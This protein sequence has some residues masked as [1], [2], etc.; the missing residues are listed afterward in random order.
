[1]AHLHE[2]DCDLV[3]VDLI[4]PDLD[5]I[6]VVRR[7]RH[8]QNPHR[9]DVPFIAL[10]ANVAQ[11]AVDNCLAVGMVEVMPK[12][13]HRQGLLRAIQAHARKA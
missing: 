10:T 8:F 5:G 12:P 1:M 6:E 4:M 11:E 9:R 2:H 3:L 7:T 13:F